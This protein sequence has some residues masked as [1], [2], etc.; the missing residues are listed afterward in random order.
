[1]KLMVPTTTNDP[2]QLTSRIS[3]AT[4]GGVS[5]LPSR[6][7][8]CVMPCA[9][10]RFSAGIQFD[11]ARVATGSA[12]TPMPSSTRPRI[13]PDRLLASPISTVADDQMMAKTVS[14]RRAPNLSA[15]HPP[16]TWKARYGYANAEKIRPTC[17]LVR[18]SSG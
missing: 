10:P 8:A 11:I 6:A 7:N 9:K 4:S 18:C 13:M 16:A 1:M 17:V 15:T 12:D 2:R 5:A 3:H 14:A